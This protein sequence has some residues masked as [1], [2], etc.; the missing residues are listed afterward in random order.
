[1]SMTGSLMQPYEGSAGGVTRAGKR[2]M[3]VS[4]SSKSP[5]STSPGPSS[6][7]NGGPSPGGPNGNPPCSLPSSASSSSSCSAAASS[8]SSSSLTRRSSASG[9]HHHRHHHHHSKR[10]RDSEDCCCCCCR[11]LGRKLH[12]NSLWSVWYGFVAL[13]LEACVISAALKRMAAVVELPWPAQDPPPLGT[14]PLH[15]GPGIEMTVCL[16][17]GAL[18]VVLV[19]PFL[20][21]AVF[22]VG[23]LA[24]DGYKHGVQLDACS[25]DPSGLSLG[26]GG[27]GGGGSGGLLGSL[28]THGGPTAPFL[29]LVSAFC[30]LLA[31]LIMEARLIQA[32]FLPKD[33][34]WRT[35]LD[36]LGIHRDRLV[37]LNFLSSTFNSS[38]PLPPSL[39]TPLSLDEVILNG[40][41]SS[42]LQMTTTTT[43]PPTTT[44]LTTTSSTTSFPSL[45]PPSASAV[46]APSPMPS[47]D[48]DGDL[49]DGG[50]VWWGSGPISTE[51]LNY[52]LALTAY[53]VRYPSVFWR[54]SKPLASLLSVQL[55]A[56]AIYALL[57]FASI[58]VLYKV[59]VV[60][61]ADGSFGNDAVAAGADSQSFLLSFFSSLHG[62]G[63]EGRSAGGA[64]SGNNGPFLLNPLV[65]LAL[66]VLSGALVLASSLVLYLYGLCRL[67][68]FLGRQR[69]RGRL[70]TVPGSLGEGAGGGGGGWGY[71]SH[72]A[73]LCVLI[74][75]GVCEAPLLHDAALV[76]RGSLDGAVLAGSIA[77]VMHL[78][79]WLLAWLILTAKRRWAFKVRVTV[80]RAT[81]RAS[82]RSVQLLTDVELASRRHNRRPHCGSSGSDSSAG[83][84]LLVVGNG[85]AYAVSETTPRKA[86]MGVV[87]RTILEQQQQRQRQR[88]GI[89]PGEDGED[90]GGGMGDGDLLD[91]DDDGE[92][93]YWLRPQQTVLR[94][95]SPKPSPDSERLTWLHRKNSSSSGGTKLK[96]T[97]DDSLNTG[98]NGSGA[99]KLKVLSKVPKTALAVGRGKL[100]GTGNGPD[101]VGEQNGSRSR[102]G[103][104][105]NPLLS[106]SEDFSGEDCEGAVPEDD[107]D[108]ATLR[109]VPMP[110]GDDEDTP[111]EDAKFQG[112]VTPR[113]LRRA[114]SGMPHEED[115][116][117]RSE[118]VSTESSGG[119]PPEH[120]GH[121]DETSSGIHS[122]S[123]G[124]TGHNGQQGIQVVTVGPSRRS[125]SVDDLVTTEQAPR[126]TAAP[127]RSFSLQRNVQ[128][129][130]S[131]D[132]GDF[133]PPPPPPPLEESTVVIRRKQSRPKT[134]DLTQAEPFGRSTNMRMTSFT[135]Q[136]DGS[137]SSITTGSTVG[138]SAGPS[139]VIPSSSPS[140]QPQPI[141]DYQSRVLASGTASLPPQHH[142][143]HQGFQL[144]AGGR[145]GC[146]SF[147]RIQP[148]Q[149]HLNYPI[150]PHH[151]QHTTL[152]THHNGVRIFGGPSSLANT[153]SFKHYRPGLQLAGVMAQGP[154]YYGTAVTA[155]VPAGRPMG[156]GVV[157]G[158]ARVPEESAG[159]HTFPAVKRVELIPHLMKANGVGQDRDSANF[160]MASSGDSDNYIT[161]G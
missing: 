160:S 102:I 75:L 112:S 34:I 98:S 37:L 96:V 113:C 126:T 44:T 150:H 157:N 87:Q 114:D 141:K 111:S 10:R 3:T 43:L 107:G 93:V 78:L 125:T 152:P 76:Y 19:P 95:V 27:S 89:S 104:R 136:P 51:F 124:E 50:A 24:N 45:P 31:R 101:L 35:D 73:A 20:F 83:V 153:S 49:W 74:S 16:G 155:S 61:A 63:S 68:S 9:H 91:D 120:S 151:H 154:S 117:P 33:A 7:P 142:P 59:Q 119:S 135:D 15:P 118:S 86:I 64:G 82:P 62:R 84:P 13:V 90:S 26:G 161:H 6:A 4:P 148:Q 100:K 110:V 36:F 1:M 17:L 38:T 32:G 29:H 129:P 12:L 81:V 54:T 28:W 21:A 99:R 103:R 109:E 138:N 121:S 57:S 159:H 22:K 65:T 139:R 14:F 92:Q 137:R 8:A 108:Y 158:V 77:A 39:P 58:S 147:P 105:R 11:F 97:F 56:N 146:H 5:P 130:T 80:A 115:V 156:V 25:R 48:D 47:P 143:P 106:D 42:V 128:P 85:R 123:S 53:A 41:A 70:I 145:G 40:T 46:T 133:P 140:L 71:F 132:C 69:E 144:A 122:N 23:N 66:F 149:P 131:E 94:T 52:A 55:A 60:R 67:R 116:T 2:I 72:C 18:A 79:L 30:L 88:K 134:T 127:W